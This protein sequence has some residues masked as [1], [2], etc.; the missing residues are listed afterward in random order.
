MRRAPNEASPLTTMLA[1]AAGA[2]DAT[3]LQGVAQVALGMFVTTSLTKSV[4]GILN[5]GPSILRVKRFFCRQSTMY[6]ISAGKWV[7]E[8]FTVHCKDQ[9]QDSEEVK[10]LRAECKS[11]FNKD[12]AKVYTAKGLVRRRGVLFYG[13][14][15]SG[16]TTLAL[17]LSAL[18]GC[19]VYCFVFDGGDHMDGQILTHLYSQIKAP[20]VVLLEDIDKALEGHGQLLQSLYNCIDG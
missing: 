6:K 12:T 3:F 14:P 9:S 1:A 11:F 20:A 10:T 2:V 17:I 5:S 4:D 16:K 18:A 8:T 15:G 7:A 13:P 19:N